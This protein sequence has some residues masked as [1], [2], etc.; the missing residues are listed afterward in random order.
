MRTLEILKDIVNNIPTELD[1]EWSGNEFMCSDIKWA[2]KG[3]PILL[4]GQMSEP[5]ETFEV[6][7]YITLP[8]IILTPTVT[9]VLKPKFF[10]GTYLETANEL[11][12]IRDI[13]DKIPMVYINEIINPQIDYT[14]REPYEEVTRCKIF[15]LTPMDYKNWG[16]DIAYTNAVYPMYSLLKAFVTAYNKDPR[17]G[18][19]EIGDTTPRVRFVVRYRVDSKGFKDV[20]TDQ[21][22]GVEVNTTINILKRQNICY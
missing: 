2:T 15:F 12:Q 9:A 22:S 14:G 17:T 4:D 10:H 16:N 21:L 19:I 20:F 11:V 7:E 3:I 5:V 1:G 6:G 8:N 13:L 18:K